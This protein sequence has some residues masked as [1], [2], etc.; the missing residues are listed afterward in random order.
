MHR[1]KQPY[2]RKN[3]AFQR[4][5]PTTAGSSNWKKRGEKNKD[6]KNPPKLCRFGG[7]FHVFLKSWRIRPKVSNP[8]HLAFDGLKNWTI[9]SFFDRF[10][11]FP[12]KSYAFVYL[13]VLWIY[14][15]FFVFTSVV[16][17][18]KRWLDCFLYSK[19]TQAGKTIDVEKKVF[20]PSKGV[21][22]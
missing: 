17:F 8:Y 19:C 2:Q 1:R 14:K 16:F 12:L 21:F 5:P 4:L 10:G 6:M 7:H 11:L 15:G 9:L 13:C 18:K 22:G 20:F 3:S